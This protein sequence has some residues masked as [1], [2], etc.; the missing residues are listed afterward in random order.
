MAAQPLRRIRYQEIA[1]ELRDAGHVGA[2]RV[3][4]AQRV[5][6]VGRVRRQPRHG[7]PGARAAARRRSDR[8]TAGVRLV[9]RHRAA[10]PEPATR[11]ARSRRSSRAAASCPSARSIE[12]AFVRRPSAVR[13][14]LGVDQVLRVKRLNLADGEPFAVVTVWCPAELG[15]TCRGRTSSGG[16]STSCSASRCAARRRRSA[17]TSPSADD[18]E[19]LARAR[20]LTRAA[21]PAGHDRHARPA[22][23][24]ERARLPGPPHRVRRRAAPR[25]AVD[26]PR[27]ASASSRWSTVTGAPD[28]A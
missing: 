25:R 7:P 26:R 8:R 17:P 27:P 16:R 12:F 6:A 4:A 14:L 15:P 22:G 11:S 2:G 13:K 18:A 21:L 1:D 23:A 3:A 20:R 10:A 9:R 19:L 24:D 28:V 5:R